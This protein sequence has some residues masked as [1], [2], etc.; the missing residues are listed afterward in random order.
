MSS[1]GSIVCI[2]PE[3]DLGGYTNGV[4]VPFTF[5]VVVD[6]V[7]PLSDLGPSAGGS[8]VG[9]SDLKRELG[10][11][12]PTTAYGNGETWTMYVVCELQGHLYLMAD[13]TGKQTKSNLTVTEVADAVA[14]GLHHPSTFPGGRVGKM[15][16]GLLGEIG[17]ASGV[18]DSA[19]R[20]ALRA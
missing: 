13:G 16:A 2:D 11:V 14:D 4:L 8:I 1:L 18:D 3:K 6:A 5:E 12:H 15:D 9:G 20:D 10:R 7:E 19:V 17:K